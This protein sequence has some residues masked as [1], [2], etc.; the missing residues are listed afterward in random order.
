MRISKSVEA[1]HGALPRLRHHNVV[2][3]G[4]IVLVTVLHA[5]SGID[6]PRDGAGVELIESA[7]NQLHVDIFA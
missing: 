3:D 4:R 1:I 5:G 6:V 7:P 2:G